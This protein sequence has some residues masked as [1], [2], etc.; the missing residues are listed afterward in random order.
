M[1]DCLSL[2]G[3]CWPGDAFFATPGFEGLDGLPL[4][5]FDADEMSEGEA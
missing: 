3:T 1:P 5:E 2:M 4:G